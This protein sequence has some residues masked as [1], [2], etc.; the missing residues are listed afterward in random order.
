MQKF[1][2]N[3]TLENH[4]AKAIKIITGSLNAAFELT[5]A[6]KWSVFFKSY[7]KNKILSKKV[8]SF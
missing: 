3:Q 1:S 8:R 4:T 5:K 6:I 2:E 7:E